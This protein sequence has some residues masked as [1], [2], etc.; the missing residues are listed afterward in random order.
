MLAGLLNCGIDQGQ[1]N[2]G[3][4]SFEFFTPFSGEVIIQLGFNI[5][6]SNYWTEE[7]EE[8]FNEETQ[9]YE[10]YEVDKSIELH[11]WSQQPNSEMKG[12]EW[13]ANIPITGGSAQLSID[14][15]YRWISVFA[16]HPESEN[17]EA[18]CFIVNG[19]V[20]S[21]IDFG[22]NVKS[23]LALPASVVGETGCSAGGKGLEF[24]RFV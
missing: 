7:T 13:V 14:N 11:R 5:N 17:R 23:S 8:V 1:C 2:H 16:A 6:I 24:F 3:G 20:I 4:K 21:L 15:Q 10:Y 22:Q 9:D 18:C 19:N 12:R